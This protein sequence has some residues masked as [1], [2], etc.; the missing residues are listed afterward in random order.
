[1]AVLNHGVHGDG[2]VGLAAGGAEGHADTAAVAEQGIEE[3]LH[4]RFAAG[5]VGSGGADDLA[6][7]GG[8]FAGFGVLLADFAIEFVEHADN[9]RAD[10]VMVQAGAVI[11]GVRH[12]VAGDAVN[13]PT[14]FQQGAGVAF[15]FVFIRQVHGAVGRRV[16]RSDILLPAAPPRRLSRTIRTPVRTIISCH[17][18]CCSSVGI[19]IVRASILPG[20]AAKS[21]TF[22]MPRYQP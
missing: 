16:V 1:M 17:F 21:A 19:L 22:R 7:I 4:R 11:A 6:D 10:A 13:I 3:W 8:D 5:K 15:Q 14:G 12:D 2:M 9:D 18:A 20:M